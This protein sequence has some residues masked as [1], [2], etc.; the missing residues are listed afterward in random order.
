M[1]EE[2]V[3]VGLSETP[4]ERVLAL[5]KA[6]EARLG[7]LGQAMRQDPPL[8]S[9]LADA[10]LLLLGEGV[11]SVLHDG[12]ES[13]QELALARTAAA[14]RARGQE[15]LLVQLGGASSGKLKETLEEALAMS[16]TFGK[17]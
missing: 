13:P 12:T 7:E 14:E 15:Q 6:A 4:K 10:Y 17:P 1:T 2:S 9:E 3:D 16:R 11:Q 5:Y 8:A